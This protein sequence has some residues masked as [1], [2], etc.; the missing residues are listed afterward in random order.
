MCRRATRAHPRRRR[1]GTRPPARSRH[2]P[3]RPHLASRARGSS[4]CSL[5]FGT[6]PARAK[7]L[8]PTTPPLRSCPVTTPSQADAAPPIRYEAEQAIATITLN[9]PGAANAQNSQMIEE[10]DAAFDRAVADDDVRVIVLAA[11]GKHFSAGHDLKE[12]L[13]GEE[14]WSAMRATPEGKLRHEQVM[15]FD[16]LVK[17]RDV[18]KP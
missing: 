3:L 14:H 7:Q 18:R 15:Y 16:K 12:L 4:T 11:E 10:L 9:R 17:I 1:A 5:R 13:A 6:S 2:R 8:G